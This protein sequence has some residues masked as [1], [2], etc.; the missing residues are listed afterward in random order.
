[1][2][3]KRDEKPLFVN[4]G[5]TIWGGTYGNMEVIIK[6]VRRSK[7]LDPV[8]ENPDAE[9]L[10]SRLLSSFAQPIVMRLLHVESIYVES[11]EDEVITMVF[12]K[13]KCDLLESLLENGI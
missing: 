3:L 8:L 6:D 13:G 7:L 5:K 1:M 4:K 11:M 9:E 2:S 10:F 12:E